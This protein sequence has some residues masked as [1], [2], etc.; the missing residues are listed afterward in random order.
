MTAGA[1][2]VRAHRVG[3][4]QI[5]AVLIAAV[6]VGVGA[7]AALHFLVARRTPSA[8]IVSQRHGLEGQM[9]WAAGSRAAPAITTL[10]DQTGRRFS[11]SALRGQTVALVFFDSHCNQECPLQGRELAAAEASLPA[12][13]RPTLVAVSVNPLDTPASA[14]KAATAWGLA[15]VAPWHW[16]MG[17]RAQLAR[18][19]REYHIY[20]GRG[21]TGDIPH[22]EALLLID[23]RGY[24]RSGYLYPFGQR[25]VTHDLGVLGR[26]RRS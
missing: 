12:A 16:L 21:T 6:L 18:V 5:A 23:R 22:T 10:V 2:T 26:E 24:E 17:T 15:G 3:P 20:V 25:F 8:T 9:T 14:R 4:A 7:G 13:Q 19:W 11:L 1:D